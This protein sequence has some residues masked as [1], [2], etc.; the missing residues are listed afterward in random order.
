MPLIILHPSGLCSASNVPGKTLIVCPT[1]Y[2]WSRELWALDWELYIYAF[3][4]TVWRKVFTR[5]FVG[6][7]RGLKKGTDP[8]RH[9]F[10][11]SRDAASISWVTPASAVTPR[12]WLR[13]RFFS[14]LLQTSFTW[15][16]LIESEIN[17]GLE[18]RSSKCLL[19]SQS[20]D[21]QEST[22][23]RFSTDLNLNWFTSC[24]DS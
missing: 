19:L 7:K 4:I 10:L 3:K 6:P 9:Q 13:T 12:T 8:I 17:M 15:G 11:S 23:G 22:K 5:N 20:S 18:E 16:H 1:T 24:P 14:N 21:E 2:P